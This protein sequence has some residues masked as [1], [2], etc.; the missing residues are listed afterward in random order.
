[1][2]GWFFLSVPKA[3]AAKIKKTQAGRPRVGWGSIRVVATLGNSKWKTSIFP[4]KKSG[5]YLLPLKAAVRKKEGMGDK[6]TVAYII[7]LQG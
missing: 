2:A 5:T 3:A 1:M 6:D 7:D 4:D